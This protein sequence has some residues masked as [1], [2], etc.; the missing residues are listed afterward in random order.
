MI[1]MIKQ[2]FL[3]AIVAPL[4]LTGC[5]DLFDKGDTERAY[6]GP[7]QVAFRTV[8]NEIDEGSSQTLEIQFISSKGS[9]D[10]DIDVSFSVNNS[11]T[12]ANP[13]Y[14]TVPSSPATISSG[15]TSTTITVDT[16]DDPDVGS[17]DEVR[18]VLEITDANGAEVA[19]NLSTT[20]IFIEGQ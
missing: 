16:S 4:L 5:D 3:A 2:I 6:D 18:V 13:D 14:Y 12:T 7:D 17:G 9:A 1:K 8:D 10:S 15:S 19:T 20:T 11:E